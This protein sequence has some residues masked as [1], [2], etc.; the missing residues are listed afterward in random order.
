MSACPSSVCRISQIGSAFHQMGREGVAQDMGA[1]LGRI[2]PCADGQGF[3]QLVEA[4]AREMALPAWEQVPGARRAHRQPSRQHLARPRAYGHHALRAALPRYDE[5]GR[6]PR[7]SSKWQGHKFAGPQAGTI[8][9]FDEGQE[10][11]S[12]RII[13]LRFLFGPCEQRIDLLVA[14]DLWQGAPDGRAGQSVAGIIRTPLFIDQEA[15]ILPQCRGLARSR[16]WRKLRPAR[17]E[18]N[19]I[20]GLGMRQ[21]A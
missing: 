2:D 18:L 13:I 7:D 8:E 6:V 19:Q 20:P 15:V 21:I 5:E 16:G 10:P 12:W 14:Q 17:F 1:D 11:Q 3:H 9:Q 4:N